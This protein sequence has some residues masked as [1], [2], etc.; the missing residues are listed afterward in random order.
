MTRRTF[1][2]FAAVLLLTFPLAATAKKR[3]G[4][5]GGK[6]G[7]QNRNRTNPGPTGDGAKR[8]EGTVGSVDSTRRIVVVNGKEGPRTYQVNA[9]A[10]IE[11]PD[12][13]RATLKDVPD[14]AQVSVRESKG[15]G[16]RFVATAITVK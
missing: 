10:H 3:R 7:N 16:G 8:Y 2:R 15:I 11:T 9:S 13:K 14:G 5:K 1:V 6:K 4:G 12:K